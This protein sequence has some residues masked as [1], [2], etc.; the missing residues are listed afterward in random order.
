MAILDGGDGPFHFCKN[1]IYN[2]EYG[3]RSPY[4]LQYYLCRFFG[5]FVYPPLFLE[6]YWSYR[7]VGLVAI[8]DRGEGP[9]HFCKM[10]SMMWFFGMG[11]SA[12]C[13]KGLQ[14]GR[15]GGHIG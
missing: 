8:L 15:P 14:V 7:W 11:F 2:V 9:F 10:G 5:V 1:G 13:C 6:C 12:I 4:I 3:V